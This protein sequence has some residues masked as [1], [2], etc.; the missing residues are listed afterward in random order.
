MGLKGSGKNTCCDYFK[1]IYNCEELSFAGP[2]KESVWLTYKHLIKDKKRIW[3]ND[4]EKSEPIEAMPISEEAYNQISFIDREKSK[5]WSGRL[6]LQYHG[7]E[8][9]KLIYPDLFTDTMTSSIKESNSSIIVV[10]DLRF[11]NEGELLKELEDLGD[12]TFIPVRVEK[13]PA[14]EVVDMHSSE[15]QFQEIEPDIIITNDFTKPIENL[16][17]QLDK[18]NVPKPSGVPRLRCLNSN[19]SQS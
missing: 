9:R 6:L 19:I 3:G 16:Y 13:I 4:I 15:T 14:P 12:I 18:I 8:V 11:I 10:S 7:T 1:K 2:L 5:Y 17:S